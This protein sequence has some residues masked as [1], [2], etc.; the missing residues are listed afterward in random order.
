MAKVIDVSSADIDFKKGVCAICKKNP[1][2]RWCDFTTKYKQNTIFVRS[3]QDFKQANAYG[4]QNE[5]CN[6]PMCEDCAIQQVGDMHL[7]PHH[8]ELMDQSEQTVEYL[9][10]RQK[11][12]TIEILKSSSLDQEDMHEN[13]FYF[14][15]KRIVDENSEL[16]KENVRM[17]KKIAS[18]KKELETCRSG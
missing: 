6:L 12:E 10:M 3:Y 9:R 14:K 13:D 5:Q 2:T 11:R 18:L 17:K 16:K 7:C 4:A 8:Q 1:V 15:V